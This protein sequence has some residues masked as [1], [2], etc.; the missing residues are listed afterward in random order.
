MRRFL[1]CF[2]VGPLT[3]FAV[4]LAT[5]VFIGLVQFFAHVFG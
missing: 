5:F 4:S 1:L 3:L 2:V